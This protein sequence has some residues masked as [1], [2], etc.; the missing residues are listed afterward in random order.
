M[1]RGRSR[2]QQRRHFPPAPLVQSPSTSILIRSTR[3]MV[4]QPREV[5][6][7]DGLH[8]DCGFR[9]G[10]RMAIDDMGPICPVGSV[11][12]ATPR[13]SVIRQGEQERR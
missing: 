11:T 2:A 13:R 9:V 7:P 6:H 12:N 4:V 10:R 5:I 3:S 1:I 8:H